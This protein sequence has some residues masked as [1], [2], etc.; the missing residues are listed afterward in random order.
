[1]YRAFSLSKCRTRRTGC[2]RL[3]RRASQPQCISFRHRPF[4]AFGRSSLFH[5]TLCTEALP[6]SNCLSGR[7]PGPSQ[8]AISLFSPE[9]GTLHHCRNP[10]GQASS[11][12]DS[13]PSEDSTALGI[14]LAISPAAQN[15]PRR[16]QAKRKPAQD[17]ADVA[18]QSAQCTEVAPLFRSR[19]EA[20]ARPQL[21]SIVAF[22]GSDNEAQLSSTEYDVRTNKLVG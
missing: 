1:M 22:D 20:P 21:S 8:N 16:S 12:Q 7:S 9:K 13:I 2:S 15:R 5:S 10:Q 18:S 11:N 3:T 14:R 4:L 19:G 6:P 17:R